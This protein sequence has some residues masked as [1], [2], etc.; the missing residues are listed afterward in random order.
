VADL[1]QQAGD[2]RDD[3][4]DADRVQSYGGQDQREGE[5]RAGANEIYR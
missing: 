1:A 3:Q 4:A 2:D 5:L